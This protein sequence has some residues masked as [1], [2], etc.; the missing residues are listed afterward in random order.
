MLDNM[1]ADEKEFSG[2]EMYFMILFRINNFS[3]TGT[4][5][6]FGKSRQ[7][8]FRDISVYIFSPFQACNNCEV[9]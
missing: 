2:I 7:E 6:H 3:T 8:V 5:F 9:D 1:L 4:G